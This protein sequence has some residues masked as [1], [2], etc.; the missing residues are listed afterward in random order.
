M[1]N[2][3]GTD[4]LTYTL[5]ETFFHGWD[6]KPGGDT[7]MIKFGAQWA[8]EKEFNGFR[9]MSLRRLTPGPSAGS[10]LSVTFGR[11]GPKAIMRVGE[12]ELESVEPGKRMAIVAPGFYSVKSSFAVDDVVVEGHL[13][14]RF[15][16]ANHLALRTEKPLVPEAPA[17]ATTDPAIAAMV[18]AYV[19]GKES[20]AT[21]VKVVGE[22]T[23]A[24]T[25][26]TAVVGALKRG[27]R[28]AL[29]VVVDL[30]YHADLGVREAGIEIVKALAG[31]DYGF[32]PKG[33]EKA[34]AS[35]IQRLN[36]DLRDHPELLEGAPG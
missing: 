9:Y 5:V 13:A 14:K 29:P 27:P 26:R 22:T 32:S 30:L 35:A 16:A 18:A 25:D 17:A 23:R 21:L 31:K 2:E 7:G 28:R 15:V 12:L 20:P 36:N 33:S 24:A 34:R 1:S 8:T 3:T 19:A 6:G 11:K 4:Y 10:A